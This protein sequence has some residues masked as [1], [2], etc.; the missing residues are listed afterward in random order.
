VPSPAPAPEAPPP[1]APEAPPPAAASEPPVL[2]LAAS[3]FEEG[4]A[5]LS[6]L[7]DEVRRGVSRDRTPEPAVTGE[8]LGSVLLTLDSDRVLRLAAGLGQPPLSGIAGDAVR[9]RVEV[10][11]PTP[12][13]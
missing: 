11:R 9:V 2:R 3:T 4:R 10:V 5:A 12:R 8:P 1:V 7:L 13:R 6:V